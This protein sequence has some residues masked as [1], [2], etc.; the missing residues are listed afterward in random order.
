MYRE[1]TVA[2]VI[3]AHNEA[4]LIGSTLEG[5]PSFIDKIFVIDDASQDNTSE[6]LQRLG[7]SDPRIKPIRH[8]VCKG[9]GAGIVTGYRAAAAEG[10]DLVVVIGG[11]NQMPC[12]QIPVL[13]D[14]L[15][16]GAADYTK[17]NRFFGHGATWEGMPK[18][19]ILGNTLITAMTKLASGYFKVVDVVDGFTA[20][21]RGV[22]E[23]INW[24]RVWAGYGYPMD[25][26]IWLNI[27]G[28][29]V[30]DVPRRA[31]YFPGERQS[32]IKAASYVLRVTP[33]LLRGFFRRLFYKYVLYDFHPLVLFYL[34]G[35]L[36]LP[37]GLLLG[38][39]L[40]WLQ[41]TGVGVSG[42]RAVL[43]A[44]LSISGLQS[45]FFAMFFDMSAENK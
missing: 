43:C 19:R 25:F 4:K 28:F 45:L 8:E 27:Y 5:I 24:N 26:L 42:P 11:D 31:I 23:S 3:P 44:L 10:I 16:D 37:A 7:R 32:Q 6:I 41:I 9:P 18:V 29:R 1:K 17:G 33:M 12:E 36:L 34:L 14:P 30:K 21:T 13:L 20:T 39:Y 22:I 15:I 40:V 35:V 2:I 38:L